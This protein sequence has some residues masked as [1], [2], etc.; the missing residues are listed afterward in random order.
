MIIDWL[1]IVIYLKAFCTSVAKSF[2]CSNFLLQKL[3]DRN[4][5]S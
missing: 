5:E 4:K 1:Q 2:E 3:S